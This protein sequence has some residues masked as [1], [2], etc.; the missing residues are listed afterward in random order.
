M[1]VKGEGFDRTLG[2]RAFDQ[3]M[4]DILVRKFNALPERQGKVDIKE[5]D[6]V[7]LRLFKLGRRLKETLSASKSSP[8]FISDIM[9]GTSLSFDLSREE[10]EKECEE[11][12]SR[13]AAPIKDALAQAELSI[14]QIN[15]VELIG[16]SIHMPKVQ[17]AIK[18]AVDNKE[19]STHLNA[20]EAMSM[21]AAYIAANIAD[22][23]IQKQ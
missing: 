4:V 8:I 5:N 16:G 10:F 17:E 6:R 15:F 9:D 2:G 12:Y 22:L 18:A 19:L 7:M 21:G 1:E 11:L 13:I 3:K 20:D 23:P 14:D